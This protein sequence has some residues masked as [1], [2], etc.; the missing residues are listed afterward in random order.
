MEIQEFIVRRLESIHWR[1]IPV[2]LAGL[3]ENCLLFKKDNITMLI[4]TGIVYKKQQRDKIR[5][6]AHQN[7]ILYRSTQ[8]TPDIYYGHVT[9][10]TIPH[11]KCLYKL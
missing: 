10:E 1:Y 8:P 11:I 3:S 4:E 7:A 5:K 9:N 2:A 6:L